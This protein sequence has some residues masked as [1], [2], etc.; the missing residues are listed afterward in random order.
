MMITSLKE[1]IKKEMF[2]TTPISI[3]INPIYILRS[4]IYK[5]VARI[6]QDLNGNILDIGCGTKPYESLFTKASSYTGVDIEISGHDHKDSKVDYFYDGKKLPF[7]NESFDVVVSFEVFEHIF[8]LDEVLI[9]IYRVLKPHGQILISVP[10]AWDEHEI[11]Y[12]FARYTSYGLAHILK[13]NGFEPTESIKTT[14]YVLAIFQILIAYLTQYVLPQGRISG[15]LAQLII[16]FPLNIAA[17]FFNAIL[18]K[19][20]EYFCNNVVLAKKVC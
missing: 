15:R 1:K 5:S 18:P 11:P 12:D 13:S 20:Y 7:H 19:R 16:I 10:F 6:A 8:N 2:I 4:G 9:E 14:T 3:V 17:L